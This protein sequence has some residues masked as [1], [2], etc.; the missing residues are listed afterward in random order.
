MRKQTKLVAVLSAAALMAIGASATAF[1]DTAHWDMED[2]EWVYLDRNGDKVT[3]EWKRSNGYWYYLD[4]DGYMAR[5]Q[6]IEDDDDKYYVDSNGVRVTNAWVSFDNDDLLDDDDMSEEVDTVWMYFDSTGKALG[7]DTSNGEI[8][9]L[10]Y[11]DGLSGYFIFNE[12]GYMLSGWQRWSKSGDSEKLYYLGTQN[13]GWAYT[14][15]QYLTIDPDIDAFSGINEDDDDY[16]DEEWFY[17]RSDGKAVE[18]TTRTINGRVYVFDEFGRM[19]DLWVY[20]DASTATASGTYVSSGGSSTA[21]DAQYYTE[22]VGNRGRNWVYA[23]PVSD[24]DDYDEDAY[25]F[26]L[27][28]NGRPFRATED[29]TRL[30]AVGAAYRIDDDNEPDA[31]DPEYNGEVG[32]RSISGDTYLFNSNGVMLTGLYWLGGENEGDTDSPVYKGTSTSPMDAGYYY[33]DETDGSTEGQMITNKKLTIDVDGDD[34]QYYFKKSGAAY[35]DTIISGT[36]Y[37]HDGKRM[38]DYGDGSTYQIVTL[39]YDL[40]EKGDSEP[41]VTAGNDVLINE[42]GKI[43]KSGTVTDVNGQKVRVTNYVVTSVEDDD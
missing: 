25:W 19:L 34:E 32:A 3:D 11:G 43:K 40:Y 12:D 21:T 27:D 24:Y 5:D 42:N 20:K 16:S 1:A 17:F 28:T 30:T 29:N 36:V 26:Y 14:G 10:S 8:K 13:E 18:D 4:E 35:T 41:C 23:Y 9:R 38:D 15:W 22:D 2:G 7:C 33:F 39:E 37:G 6:V 31:D